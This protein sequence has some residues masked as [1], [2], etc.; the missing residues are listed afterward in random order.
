MIP[1]RLQ[2]PLLQ[3]LHQDHRGI[4]IV[5]ALARSYIWWPGLDYDIEQMVKS[6]VPCQS[7]RG[8][9]S[10]APLHP[11]LWPGKPWQ[12]VHI[13]F[14][15]PVEKR[16]LLIMFDAHSKWPEVIEMPIQN[17]IRDDHSRVKK[18]FCCAWHTRTTGL[19]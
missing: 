6:C 8:N 17:H 4:C 10:V 12:R 1:L 15:G 18:G 11:W 3:E 14:A 19:R 2:Q 13:D 7:V 16:M 9:P 5:K